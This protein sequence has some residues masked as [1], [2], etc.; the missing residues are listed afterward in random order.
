MKMLF[1]V[2]TY[3]KKY[4]NKENMRCVMRI[5]IHTAFIE[6]QT[7]NP[8]MKVFVVPEGNGILLNAGYKVW[9]K[10]ST[11]NICLSSRSDL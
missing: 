3:Q 5:Q 6:S 8:S 2:W 1:Q 7:F 10:A 9:I 4:T 11:L